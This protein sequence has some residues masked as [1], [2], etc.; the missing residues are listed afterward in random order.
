MPSTSMSITWSGVHAPGG[1]SL[2]PRAVMPVKVE[3]GIRR[4]ALMRLPSSLRRLC[5]SASVSTFTPALLTL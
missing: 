4:C 1:F 5:A 2:R 3:P